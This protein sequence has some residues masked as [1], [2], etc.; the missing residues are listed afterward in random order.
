MGI[1]HRRLFV[2]FVSAAVVT[3]ASGAAA[4]ATDTDLLLD[5]F[6]R[7]DRAYVP[8]LALTKM[9]TQ[10][11]SQKA[12][13]HLKQEWRKFSA[14]HR[15][16]MPDDRL[17]QT[18]FNRV[19]EAIADAERHL[20]G[21]Q[22]L[23]AHESL[24]AIREIFLE[25]R[26]RNELIYY[27]DYLTEFHTTMEE[28]VLAVKVEKPGDLGSNSIARIRSLTQTAVQQWEQVKSA[29]FPR[30]RFEFGEEKLAQRQQL[31]KAETEALRQLTEA[32]HGNDKARIVDAGR[33]IKPIFAKSF[34]LFGDFPQQVKR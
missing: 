29:P 10:Q 8:A 7:F 3:A 31:L 15:G 17:W 16:S 5:D 27:L 25:S 24:E 23:D 1:R 28:I 4:M 32:I 19:C 14:S 6:A 33:A 21:N 26:R 22:Q 9:G 13:G 2:A 11:A 30:E 12:L 18:D 20:K 34:M